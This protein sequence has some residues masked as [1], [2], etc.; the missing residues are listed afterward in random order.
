MIRE[1]AGV[2]ARSIQGV[3]DALVDEGVVMQCMVQ[4]NKRDEPAYRLV[5][6]GGV[7]AP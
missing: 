4:K 5:D 3:L 1:L 7:G 6:A 2:G